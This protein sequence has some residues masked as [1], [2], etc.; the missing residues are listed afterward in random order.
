M[1]I[2][3]TALHR[4]TAEPAEKT[5]RALLE[6]LRAASNC[7]ARDGRPVVEF[8]LDLPTVL[9]TGVTEEKLRVLVEEGIL[10]TKGRAGNAPSVAVSKRSGSG[11]R[12]SCSP[13]PATVG[14]PR[15]CRA[16]CF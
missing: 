7:A 2:A 11:I 3:T 4:F 10:T 16:R 13:R 12:S 6:L 15:S 5:L 9:R 1:S 8:A 14:P